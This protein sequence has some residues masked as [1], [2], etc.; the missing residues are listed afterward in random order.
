VLLAPIS[1][2]FSCADFVPAVGLQCC[3]SHCPRGP[4]FPWLRGSAV[5][6]HRCFLVSQS[7][8][9]GRRSR[10][11]PGAKAGPCCAYL[12]RSLRS[13]TFFCSLLRGCRHRPS[14]PWARARWRRRRLPV[15][16]FAAS[17]LFLLKDFLLHVNY[18]FSILTGGSW[19]CSWAI[20][21]KTQFFWVSCCA[22][23]VNS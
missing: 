22:S 19:S 7:W 4:I 5:Q 1:S 9:C 2:Y 16:V 10:V 11:Q 20:R 8:F 23:L 15:F 6:P 13:K 14:C 17:Q 3:S 12:A 21:S 18:F